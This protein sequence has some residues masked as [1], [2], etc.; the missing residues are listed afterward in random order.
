VTSPQQ[1]WS[2][3]TDSSLVERAQPRWLLGTLAGLAAGLVAAVLYAVI[4]A[5][6]NSEILYLIIGV[7]VVA[8]LVVKMVIRVASPATA[9]ISFLV[10][11]LSVATAIYLVQAVGLWG[12]LGTALSHLGDTSPGTMFDLYF[13]DP[14][15]YVWAGAG[16]IAALV[17][18]LGALGQNADTTPA[19]SGEADQPVQHITPLAP[20]ESK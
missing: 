10:G 15:G 16:V 4:T 18:G 20:P 6:A 19:A 8:G 7:G 11:T 14:L 5:V 9:A 2:A 12:D 3:P 13:S 1:S 17:V